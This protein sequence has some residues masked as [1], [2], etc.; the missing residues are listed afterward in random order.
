MLNPKV[1]KFLEDN[2]LTY[3]FLMLANMEVERL[4][5]LPD[6]IKS[7]FK[8]K[9]TEKA[10]EHVALNVIPDYIGDLPHQEE[11]PFA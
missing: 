8:G 4:V 6:I 7:Q 3:L 9:L 1:E 2:N 5:S 10:L 11:D